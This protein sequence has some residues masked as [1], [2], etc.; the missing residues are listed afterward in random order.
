MTEQQSY[1][2]HP[3]QEEN[4]NDVAIPLVVVLILFVLA[5]VI[6]G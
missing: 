1:P 3:Y 2:Y 6:W 4:N 5:N